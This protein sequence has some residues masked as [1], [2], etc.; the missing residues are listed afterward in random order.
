MRYIH[1]IS[2]LLQPGFT[3]ICSFRKTLRYLENWKGA[4]IQN[5]L[6]NMNRYLFTMTFN[7][8]TVIKSLPL[9]NDTFIRKQV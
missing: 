2:D 5:D 3:E 8:F 6:T 7:N 9:F 1:I 4:C